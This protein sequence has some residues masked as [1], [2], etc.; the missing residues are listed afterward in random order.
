MQPPN[1]RNNERNSR[2]NGDFKNSK[3]EQDP[4]KSQPGWWPRER[5]VWGG[6]LDS[7]CAPA[8]PRTSSFCLFTLGR[9]S[10]DV[11]GL[12]RDCLPYKQQLSWGKRGSTLEH[13]G[14]GSSHLRGPQK[15]GRE[16][17]MFLLTRCF[18][19][20]L[21]CSTWNPWRSDSI[22]TLPGLNLLFSE[23]Q[24]LSESEKAIMTV[25][26]VFRASL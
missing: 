22:I 26:I 7:G 21:L 17:V 13:R 15:R 19:K 20:Y 6:P 16:G 12:L 23:N 5:G 14:S 1:S 24:F 9:H 3:G 2:N 11:A 10:L 4:G 8:V 18:V 25:W